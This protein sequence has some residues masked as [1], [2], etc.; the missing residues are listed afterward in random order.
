MLRLPNV[1]QQ[2]I[3]LIINRLISEISQ[4]SNKQE[5]HP[6]VKQALELLAESKHRIEKGLE[7]PESEARALYQTLSSLFLFEQL[8]F[9]DKEY[10][11]LKE[12]QQFAHHKGAKGGL[13]S[14]FTANAW[15]KPF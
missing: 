14:L 1:N 3:V 12:I 9:T 8:Q 13:E 11:L 4:R 2:S 7:T 10:R 15:R 6:G 5:G